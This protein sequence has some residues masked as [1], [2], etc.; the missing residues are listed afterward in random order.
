[1]RRTLSFLLLAITSNSLMVASD[2]LN[3][4]QVLAKL[5]EA[6]AKTDIFELPS[7]TMKAEISVDADGTTDQG[8]YV[9]FWNGPN[10]WREE[11]ELPRYKEVQVGG[12]GMIWVQRST[13]FIPPP[14]V[15]LRR[16]L[17]FGT[18]NGSSLSTL[19]QFVLRDGEVVKSQERRKERGR[20]LRCFEI[21]DRKTKF[22]NET[23]LTAM[24]CIPIGVEKPVYTAC[25][26]ENTGLIS[27]E[28]RWW[29]DTDYQKVGD[30]LFPRKVTF[31]QPGE[32]A[33]VTIKELVTGA[34]FPKDAFVPLTGIDPQP[35][36]MNPI[37]PRI[38]KDTTPEYPDVLRK[39]RKQGVVYSDAI[40]GPE[41]RIT[42][43]RV[44]RSPSPLFSDS[45]TKSLNE[46]A[47]DPAT[48]EGQPVPFATV[49]QVNFSLYAVVWG[50]PR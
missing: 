35:G 12:K 49:L 15:N 17:G 29:A 30:K 9:L 47:Y 37:P 42:T 50:V 2:K 19:P 36:C 48:C 38:T 16:A 45:A 40:I 4:E 13:S 33:T 10:E 24:T 43:K 3:Q 8:T 28:S 11:I 7:F 18:N 20:T 5:R 6:A 25:I 46:S 34:S 27:R 39:A 14:I 31:L 44:L 1:M 21:E 23:C 32:S 22:V 26:D 41:G